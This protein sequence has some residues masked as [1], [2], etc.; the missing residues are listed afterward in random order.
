M[1]VCHG[2]GTLNYIENKVFK[3][4]GLLYKAKQFVDQSFLFAL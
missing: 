4:T 2:K 3:N 1:N